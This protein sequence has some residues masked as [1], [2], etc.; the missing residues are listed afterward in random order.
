MYLLSQALP[1]DLELKKA[2][3]GVSDLFFRNCEEGE[4]NIG[5]Y[6]DIPS[7]LLKEKEFI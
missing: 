5:K 2:A 3:D 7:E 6:M 4:A 1:E